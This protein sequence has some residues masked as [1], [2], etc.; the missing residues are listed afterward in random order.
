MTR[1]HEQAGPAPAPAAETRKGHIAR[2]ADEPILVERARRGDDE[3]FS[4]LHGRYHRHIYNYLYRCAGDATVAEDLTQDVFLKAWLHLPRTL[5]K[6]PLIWGAWLYRIA[7]N[8]YTDRYR[9]ERLVQWEA[10]SA[11]SRMFHPSQVARDNPERDALDAETRREVRAVLEEVGGRPRKGNH[12]QFSTRLTP[13]Q[14]YRLLLELH[15]QHD[16]SYQEMAVLL[17][18]TVSAVKSALGRAR[19]A[20]KEAWGVRD[21]S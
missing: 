13:G 16:A 8:T 3:A 14:Q 5:D 20:F 10:W 11:F 1:T 12:H 7:T 18:T 21:A 4:V 6:G 2:Q 19:S 15:Y 9:H 17:C